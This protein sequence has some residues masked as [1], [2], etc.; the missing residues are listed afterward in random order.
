MTEVTRTCE[1]PSTSEAPLE[2][3]AIRRWSGG[4]VHRGL[5]W[6]NGSWLPVCSCGGT[7]NGS[8]RNKARVIAEGWEVTN[9]KN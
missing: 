7:A 6:P 1:V 5:R 4:K 8:L 2:K 3:V 9:C